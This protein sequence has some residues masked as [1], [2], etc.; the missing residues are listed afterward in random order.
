M[1][2]GALGEIAAAARRQFARAWP[3]ATAAA[4]VWFIIAYCVHQSLIS[5]ATGAKG[6]RRAETPRLYTALEELDSCIALD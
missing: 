3:L 5:P 6:V 1:P 2:G 4:L